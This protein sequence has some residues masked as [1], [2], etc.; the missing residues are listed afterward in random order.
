MGSKRVKRYDAAQTPYQRVL[1]AGVLPAAQRQALDQQLHAL[2]PIAVA[3][4]LR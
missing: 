4:D 1:A 2:D 3:R